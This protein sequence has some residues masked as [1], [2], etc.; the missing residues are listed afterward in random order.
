MPFGMGPRQ[1]IGM[2]FALLEAKLALAHLLK[3]F[4]IVPCDKTPVQ[5]FNKN[6]DIKICLLGQ[7]N[8]RFKWYHSGKGA[9]CDTD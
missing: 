5:F 2:R 4:K 7:I 9:G 3:N 8:F 6:Y 1:C